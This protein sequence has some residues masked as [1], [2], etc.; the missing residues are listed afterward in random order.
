MKE[1]PILHYDS[2][3]H[4]GKARIVELQGEVFLF[5]HKDAN[6]NQHE[7][8]FKSLKDA[9]CAYERVFNC[10]LDMMQWDLEFDCY[11]YE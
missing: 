3:K 4:K 1:I 5:L 6:G 11:F 8:R 7:K 2:I 9:I 10:K